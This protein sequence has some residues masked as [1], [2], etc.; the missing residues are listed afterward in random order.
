MLT[1]H[2]ASLFFTVDPCAKY[3]LAVCRELRYLL[4]LLG[5][6][7]RLFH[8][9]KTEIGKHPKVGCARLGHQSGHRSPLCPQPKRH[10]GMNPPCLT[11]AMPARRAPMRG[12]SASRATNNL[13]F[14]SCWSVSYY[15][16]SIPLFQDA[17][18]GAT[19]LSGRAWPAIQCK[20]VRDCG[21]EA[22]MTAIGGTLAA[23]EPNRHPK[24]S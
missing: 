18:N 15:I 20:H 2:R 14:S 24:G 9:K 10:G 8:C 23:G 11:R 12:V 17:C 21:S 19:A 3:S 5:Q 7:T 6:E 13:F 22:A 4:K 16:V 1:P